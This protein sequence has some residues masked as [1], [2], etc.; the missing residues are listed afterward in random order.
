M[1]RRSIPSQPQNVLLHHEENHAVVGHQARE[2]KRH[3]LKHHQASH[4]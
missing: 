1:K 2:I 4:R 3:S